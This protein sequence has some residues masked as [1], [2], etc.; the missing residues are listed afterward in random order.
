MA[1]L[2][3]FLLGYGYSSSR[4]LFDSDGSPV[5]N[6]TSLSNS[7][8]A[9]GG[10][11]ADAIADSPSKRKPQKTP[12]SVNLNVLTTEKSKKLLSQALRGLGS[13][14]YPSE[15]EYSFEITKKL[16]LSLGVPE[17]DRV[18]KRIFLKV[19][20]PVQYCEN[21]LKSRLRFYKM[22]IDSD[23]IKRKKTK[24]KSKKDKNGSKGK[25]KD[26]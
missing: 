9:L 14:W 25:D 26:F 24:D 8:M 21:R 7:M 2:I 6:R 13:L 11:R 23:S 19:Q 5:R 20:T 1:A 18:K 16:K 17:E 15:E 3:H 12:E 4:P 10:L 22:L